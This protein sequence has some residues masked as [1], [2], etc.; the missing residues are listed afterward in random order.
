MKIIDANDAIVGRLSTYAAKRLLAGEDVVIVNAQN[1]SLS[2]RPEYFESL[3]TGRRSMQSKAN[4]D[5][6]PKQSWS[7]RPDLFLRRIIRGM[8]PKDTKR[9]RDALRKLRVY[10][11]VPADLEGQR[12]KFETLP[13]RASLLNSRKTTLGELATQ[14]GW[15][16]KVGA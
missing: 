12:A 15:K 8:L 10:L 7:R 14:L 16:H 1:A 3:Y 5:E 4:P 9:G 2:G 11:G 6:S 13:K